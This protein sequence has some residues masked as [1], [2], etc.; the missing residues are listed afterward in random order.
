MC[1]PYPA[2]SSALWAL[3]PFLE[4]VGEVM[5]ESQYLLFV[6]LAVHVQHEQVIAEAAHGDACNRE[7]PQ[8]HCHRN[9]GD[10]Q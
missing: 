6:V 3:N 5:D 10:G 4:A 7:Q 9:A 8:C 1:P 2:A